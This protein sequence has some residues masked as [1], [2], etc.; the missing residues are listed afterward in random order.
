MTQT[1][2]NRVTADTVTAE[3]MLALRTEAA[4]AGDELMVLECDRALDM[5]RLL[6]FDSPAEH[7]RGNLAAREICR[8]ARAKVADAINNARAQDNSARHGGTPIL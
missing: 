6:S 4:Q 8:Q 3:Q 5:P 1:E 7:K 2:T